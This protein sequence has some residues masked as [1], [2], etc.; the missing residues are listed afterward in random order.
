M[1]TEEGSSDAP[2]PQ[3]PPAKTYDGPGPGR[4]QCPSCRVYCGVRSA[5]CPACAH[6]FKADAVRRQAERAA[7]ERAEAEARRA[8][9]ASTPEAPAALPAASGAAAYLVGGGAVDT[10]RQIVVACE[11]VPPAPMP[12]LDDTAAVKE[13]AAAC[14]R[15]R[16]DVYLTVDALVLWLRAWY[17]ADVRAALAQ[18]PG[19]VVYTSHSA[20]S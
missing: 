17:R 20:A 8:A 1:S 2:K 16:S 14:V 4:K 7:A 12:N 5:A 11:G 10:A 9:R 6:D 15:A 19:V 18:V 3:A 13:W